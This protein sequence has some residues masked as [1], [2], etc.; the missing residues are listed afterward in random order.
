MDKVEKK[1]RKEQIAK[2]N[3]LDFLL[4]EDDPEQAAERKKHH[5]EYFK[6][7]IEAIIGDRHVLKE[8]MGRIRSIRDKKSQETREKQ[9]IFK[10]YQQKQI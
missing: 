6:S 5:H 7:K 8:F 10:E 9:L 3:P 2:R 4:E 1:K